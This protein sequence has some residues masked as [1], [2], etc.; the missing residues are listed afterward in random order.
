MQVTNIVGSSES[1]TRA[2]SHYLRNAGSWP[3]QCCAKGC[4][5]NAVHGG[6]VKANMTWYIIPV[7]QNP[8]NLPA[9]E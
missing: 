3:E 4:K 8:H 6:H 9:S 2:K 1:S 5:N 7:C